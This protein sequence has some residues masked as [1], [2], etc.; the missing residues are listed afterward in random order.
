VGYV[1]ILK[2]GTMERKQF[3]EELSKLRPS[4][5][6]LSLI[7]YRNEHSEVADFSIVFHMSYENALKRSVA[8]L[9]TVVPTDTL[10]A[11]AKQE[12]IDGY[13]KSLTKIATTPIEELEDNYT[14]FFD[15]DGSYIKGV[16][17]HTESDTLHLYGLVNAKRILVPGQYP[18]RNKRELTKAKDQLRKL[19]PVEKFRQFRIRPDQVDRISVENLSLLPPSI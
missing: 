10:Q 5:T 17:L 15:A 11:L 18:T 3:V 12:L 7:G 16:K 13:T 9:E 1:C 19:C 4:A 14:R 6:F 8:A 2:E